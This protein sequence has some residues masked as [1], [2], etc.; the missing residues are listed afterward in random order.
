MRVI[1]SSVAFILEEINLVS[2][3]INTGPN[4]SITSIINND[5]AKGR[6]KDISHE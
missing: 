2:K 6:S 3:L 5:G 1:C 4:S